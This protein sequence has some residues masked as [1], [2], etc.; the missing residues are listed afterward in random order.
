MAG[1]FPGVVL[2]KILKEK[3]QLTSKDVMEAANKGDGLA[4]EFWNKSLHYLALGCI[5]ICRILDP[6]KIVLAGGMTKAGEHLIKPLLKHFQQLHWTQTD[7]K[8]EIVIG[9]LGNDAGVI[10]A[11]GVARAKFSE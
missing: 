9:K 11:A 3:G 7:I 8:T 1:E 10:G 4:E 6:D 2:G 5:D